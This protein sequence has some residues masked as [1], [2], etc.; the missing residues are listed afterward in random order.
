MALKSGKMKKTKRKNEKKNLLPSDAA[1]CHRVVRRHTCSPFSH[2]VAIDASGTSASRTWG[3]DRPASPNTP[4]EASYEA[5]NE[6]EECQERTTMADRSRAL[7]VVCVTKRHTR[8][9]LV[10]HLDFRRLRGP[11]CGGLQQPAPNASGDPRQRPR[12]THSLDWCPRRIALCSVLSAF[13][14]PQALLLGRRVFE[15]DRRD[16]PVLAAPS[17]AAFVTAQRVR[18]MQA[19]A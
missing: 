11:T 10:K 18:V 1:A 6:P 4:S 17:A 5:R 3:P 13:V 7:T 19:A 2:L 15:R 16:R 12:R 8:R 9:F 14:P